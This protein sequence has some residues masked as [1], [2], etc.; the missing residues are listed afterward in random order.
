[1]EAVDVPAVIPKSVQD[2]YG[3]AVVA[4]Q[5]GQT[6]AA[7]FMLRTVIEQWA[8]SK[9]I[10]ANETAQAEGATV[11]EQ[12]VA[13]LPHHFKETFPSMRKLYT[14]LSADL[15][16]ATVSDGLFDRA[17]QEITEH[18]DARRLFKLDG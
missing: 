10:I 15:H 17:T 1:M 4:H 5:S 6:L 9:V 16:T 13:A 18:F 14:D 11:L 7:L 12:Y 2:F 3:G 8:R